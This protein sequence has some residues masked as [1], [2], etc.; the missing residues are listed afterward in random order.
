[1]NLPNFFSLS[2]ILLAPVFFLLCFLP[3][4]TGIDG[5][6][7]FPFL[8]AVFL[9]IE[10]SDLVDGYLARRKNQITNVGK[11]LDPFSDIISRTSY[12][13]AFTVMGIMPA[14]SFLII[15]YR[16]F[17]ILFLRMILAGRNIV[18]AARISGKIKS[19]LYSLA[20]LMSLL[21]L[22]FRWVAGSGELPGLALAVQ[23]CFAVVAG[24]SL[25]SFLDYLL[26]FRRHLASPNSGETTHQ[27]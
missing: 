22:Y 17:G 20:S 5:A 1:M 7:V 26:V 6:G 2:R 9:Y 21:L 14:L 25:I 18:L 23:L 4:W 24:F 10:L 15:L 16:E 13:L 11:V 8:L 12:F 27:V 19:V 3:Q